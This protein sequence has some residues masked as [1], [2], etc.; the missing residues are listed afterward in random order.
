MC[1]GRCFEGRAL[2]SK[3]STILRTLNAKLPEIFYRQEITVGC[4]HRD[5]DRQWILLAY[6]RGR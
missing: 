1:D 4:S 5:T 3:I 2:Y 6:D